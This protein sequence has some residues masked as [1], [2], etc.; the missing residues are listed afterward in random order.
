MEKET[1]SV[2]RVALIGPESTS[3]STLSEALA[4]HYNTLWIQ[5]YAR[6]YLSKINRKYTIDDI[7]AIAKEQLFQEQQLI[8]KANRIIF[9]DTELIISKVWCEDVFKICPD[10]ISENLIK[11]QYDLYL[12]TSPDLPW[13]E[14][15]LRE[16]P[17][18]RE[19]L[20][21]WYEKELK[22]M[23]ANYEV[24][25]GVGDLRL[26]NSISLIEKYLSNI[27]N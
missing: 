16:N 5:E 12:L 26:K 17:H 7:V 19:F 2:I 4:K 24:V 25:K 27:Q 23:N 21:E 10:W 8:K 14:D 13:K 18:R 3:K 1:N 11:H 6:E 9:I 22:N 20:F 15:A